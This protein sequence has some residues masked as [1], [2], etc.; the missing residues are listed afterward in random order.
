MDREPRRGTGV[1]IASYGPA[2]AAPPPGD[3][4]YGGEGRAG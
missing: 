4:S 2:P 1:R 3:V